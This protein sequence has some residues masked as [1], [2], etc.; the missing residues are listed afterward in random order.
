MGKNTA[1]SACRTHNM[2]KCPGSYTPIANSNVGLQNNFTVRYI[3]GSPYE[4]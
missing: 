2:Q 3:K 1:S 4:N